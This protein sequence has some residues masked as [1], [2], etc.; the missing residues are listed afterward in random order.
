MVRRIPVSRV[1]QDL[2]RRI[3]SFDPVFQN[4]SRPAWLPVEQQVR[5]PVGRQ[6]NL[7]LYHAVR[8]GIEQE[9]LDQI[10]G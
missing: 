1:A 3:Q 4:I 9:W 8:A 5:D 6:I 10:P 7:S 2:H